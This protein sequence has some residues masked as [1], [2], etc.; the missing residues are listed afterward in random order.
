MSGRPAP[1]RPPI[2]F[3]PFRFLP[4][5][6]LLLAG[7][8]KVPLGSRAHD[9]LAAL[10]ERPGEVVGKQE[11]IARVWPH[12]VV[13]EANL[14]VHVAALR[15]A[16]AEADPAGG[17]YIANVPGRGYSFVAPIAFAEEPPPPADRAAAPPPPDRPAPPSPEPPPAAGRIVGRAEVIGTVAAQLRRHRCVTIA[18]PGGIGKTTVA[19]AVAEA[20]AASFRDGARIVDL[21]PLADPSLVATALAAAL[22]V[23]VLSD[24]PGRSLAVYLRDRQLLIV[25]DSCEHVI[26]AAAALAEQVIAA[27]AGVHILATSREPLNIA[28]ERVQRLAPLASPP[29]AARPTAEQ[30]L[31]F[32]AVRLFV[33]RAAA[34]LGT[35][36]LT[37]ADAPAVADICRRLDGI[38]LAIEIAAGRVDAFGVAGLAALLDDRFRLQMRDR[39]T[40]LPR[41]QTLGTTL[42]WSYSL[43]PEAE[44]AV[45]RRLA[46][47]AGGF[48]MAAAAATLAEPALGA[49]TVVE[50]VANLVGKSLLAASLGGAAA[51]YRL[52]DTTRAYAAAKLREHGEWAACARRHAARVRDVLEVAAR[53]WESRP[54]AAWLDEYRPLLD[55]ARAAI[56]RGL[57]PVGDGGT[58]DAGVGIALTVAAVPL[59]FGMS[60]V[61]E[62]EERARRALAALPAERDG[63]TA[64]AE[65]RLNAAL[66][67]SLMQTRGSVAATRTAWSRAL[68]LA[69]ALG[70][71]D[72]ALRAL[73]G[74]WAGRLNG[75]DLRGALALA[76]RFH[77]L[78]ARQDEPD[79]GFVGDRMLGYTLHLLGE[80]AA[81]RR[82]IERMLAGY[83]TPVSGARMIRFVFDQRVTS[84]CFLAR[85]LWLQ[86]FAAEAMRMVEDIVAEALGGGDALTLCQALVQAACPLALLAGD[87]AAAARFVALL[88]DTATRHGFEFWQT[89]GRSFAGLLLIQRGDVAAGVPLLETAVGELR[90]IGFGVYYTVVLA[91]LA[92]GFGQA[93]ETAEAL[94]AIGQALARSE[95]NEERWCVA[96]LLRINGELLLRRGGPGDAAAAE[97]LFRQGLDWARRQGALA[98]ELRIATALARLPQE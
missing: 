74:L 17:R 34:R 77:A 91:G 15:K 92:E 86:G 39:R 9:I 97:A 65:M 57:A 54:A 53:A 73:W 24:Q 59:W 28:Q 5:R 27:A 2:A 26:E 22:G 93:G 32:P 52:L 96:E 67:W 80:H 7:D 66:G 16:L 87:L 75:G 56:D 83:V 14:R 41:H 12:A 37:D 98:W 50:C 29:A 84:R 88:N 68:A 85:I 25:L 47:F 81:A 82:H 60:L 90:G 51:E 13:E 55:D 18:G 8:T 70:D 3:G 36:V 72:H 69:E 44:R 76:E 46:V 61:S 23:A 1:A 11:L 20:L 49:E 58:G 38:A 62:C 40:A 19:L 21:A 10:L 48:T 6:Q 95:A 42:D 64:A 71:A 33:E 4:A 30:A 89:W 45:L 43:L 31:E 78:A 79:D 35:F 94:A 63:A